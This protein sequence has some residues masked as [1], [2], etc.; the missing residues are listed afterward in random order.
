MSELYKQCLEAGIVMDVIFDFDK[1]QEYFN[2]FAK[3][4]QAAY[5]SASYEKA[6]REFEGFLVIRAPYLQ[7]TASLADPEIS[8]IAANAKRELNKIYF[9]RTAVRALNFRPSK[10]RMKPA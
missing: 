1:K 2:R 4:E 6:M 7:G 8:A 10:L 5:I 3:A 9:E